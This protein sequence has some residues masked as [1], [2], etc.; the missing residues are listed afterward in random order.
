MVTIYAL[1]EPNSEIIR[2]VGKTKRN[3]KIRFL[4]HLKNESGTH[5]S[6]WIK[7]CLKQGLLPECIELDECKEEDWELIEQYWISQCKAWG[8]DLVNAQEG[9]MCTDKYSKPKRHNKLKPFY[10]Y[11]GVN[12]NYCKDIDVFC[13]EYSIV[14]YRVTKCLRELSMTLG[15][16]FGYTKEECLNKHQEY[17]SKLIVSKKGKSTTKKQGRVIVALNLKTNESFN[18]ISISEAARQLNMKD[19]SISTHLNNNCKEKVHS[20]KGFV[21]GETLEE[22]EIKKAEYKNIFIGRVNNLKKNKTI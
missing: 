5:C 13:K 21:F 6:N 3:L 8:F 9:G 4:E 16:V 18:F 12:M 22:C 19:K 17:H 14:K 10:Y 15:F 7:S 2:Y 11:D 1:C 20:V